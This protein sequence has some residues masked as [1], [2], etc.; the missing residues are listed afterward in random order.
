MEFGW[1]SVTFKGARRVPRKRLAACR[2]PLNGLLFDRE[3]ESGHH[4]AERDELQGDAPAHQRLAGDRA[5]SPNHVP[6]AERKYS[7]DPSKRQWNRDQDKPPRKR[8]LASEQLG[9]RL[10]QPTKAVIEADNQKGDQTPP[11]V[12]RQSGSFKAPCLSTPPKA[13]AA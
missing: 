3:I 4:Q 6:Q 13:N 9:N 10:R 1:A 8:S 7:R 11:E 5:P 12:R 2:R